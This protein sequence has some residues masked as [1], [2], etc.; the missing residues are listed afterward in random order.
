M[1]LGRC[2]LK[3]ARMKRYLIFG[4]LGPFVGGFLLLLATTIVSGYWAHTNLSEVAKLFVLFVK[5]LQFSY[6]FGILPVMIFAA[7]DDIVWH[8]KWISAAMRMLIVGAL[9]FFAAAILYGGRGADSGVSQ[10]ILYGLAGL[11][12]AMLCSW[13]AGKG[14][15]AENAAA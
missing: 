4:V 2:F 9:A 6:L 15:A 14:T 5:S 8:V 1:R 12:P 11:T 10:F 3:G 13:L 7:I